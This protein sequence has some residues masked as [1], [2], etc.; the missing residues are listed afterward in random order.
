MVIPAIAIA[1][2]MALKLLA[3]LGVEALKPQFVRGNWHPPLI[4]ARK[5]ADLK[6]QFRLEGK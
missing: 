3:K 5:A 4:S 2:C 6:K 1:V